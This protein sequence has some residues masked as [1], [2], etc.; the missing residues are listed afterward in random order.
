MRRYTFSS[1]VVI[2][3][4]LLALALGPTAHA[5]HRLGAGARY[6]TAHSVFDELPYDDEM[7]YGLTYQYVED[8]SY[9]ELAATIVPN[10]K[11]DSLDYIVTPQLNLLFSDGMWRGGTGVLTTYTKD[12]TGDDDW[13]DIY[14]QMIFGLSYPIGRLS[15]DAY[16]YYV[17]EGWEDL[18]DFEFDDLEGGAWLVYSF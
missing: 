11:A 10:P 18:L 12:S 6:H 8:V 15:L 13:T 2:L 3:A 17:Y 9:F 1:T 14:W 16:V 4:A 7:S 5:G